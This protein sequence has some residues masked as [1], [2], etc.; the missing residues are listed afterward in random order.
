[1]CNIHN[2][3]NDNINNN[4]LHWN[5]NS[6][7]PMPVFPISRVVEIIF[8]FLVEEP[9]RGLRAVHRSKENKMEVE[10]VGSSRRGRRRVF[11]ELY[12]GGC[13]RSSSLV[14]PPLP[15]SPRFHTG[16]RVASLP[17][18]RHSLV[19]HLPH[20]RR[21]ARSTGS[22]SDYRYSYATL[23]NSSISYIVD[24]GL[25]SPLSSYSGFSLREP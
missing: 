1:M 22:D 14:L 10:E 13:P 16:F 4:N 8:A 11:G 17:R 15:F 5:L 9:A 21:V 25:S 23:N 24:R 18:L 7:Q 2:N 20:R 19:T 6:C 12:S 3:D